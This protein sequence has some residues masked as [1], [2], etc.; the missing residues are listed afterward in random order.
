MAMTDLQVT[1]YCPV[2]GCQV[3]AMPSRELEGLVRLDYHLDRYPFF[4]C[5]GS[6][7]T[8]WPRRNT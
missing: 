8:A 5:I 4:L 3:P 2:C 6:R 7:Q 1:G